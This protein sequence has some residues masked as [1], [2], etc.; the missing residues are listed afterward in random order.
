MQ[1]SEELSSVETCAFLRT[2][3]TLPTV[4]EELSSVETILLLYSYGYSIWVSEELSSVETSLLWVEKNQK[5][6]KFQ[7]NLVVWKP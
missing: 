5:Y 7:K 2:I 6:K 4:S 3:F 1:V